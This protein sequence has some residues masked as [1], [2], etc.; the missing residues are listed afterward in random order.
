[1]A[2]PATAS[3]APN[4][5]GCG[6]SGASPL[7]RGRGIGEA[8][9]TRLRLVSIVILVPLF[10]WGFF[11]VA[12]RWDWPAGWGCLIVLAAGAVVS[13]VVVWRANPELL[14]QRGIIGKGT[15]T[16]DIVCLAL[17]GVLYLAILVVGALDGGR[18]HWSAMS[19]WL[20]PAGAALY[21]AGQAVI[22]WCMVVNRNFEKT[23]RIQ[24]D[25][26]HAVARSGPYA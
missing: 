1:L 17:F 6:R 14:R 11:G 26:G 23:A 2:T 15:K 4:K 7:G 20:W 12:G 13:D 8:A 16:W 18:Y 21:A 25:R 24:S 19:L 22:T 3:T 10:I 5:A 9:L